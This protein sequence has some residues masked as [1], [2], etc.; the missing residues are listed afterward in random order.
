MGSVFGLKSSHFVKISHFYMLWIIVI[1]FAAYLDYFAYYNLAAV[2]LGK[3][4]SG[5]ENE[6]HSKSKAK[7]FN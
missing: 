4:Q 3:S 7:S 2:D 6:F 1:S 5:N